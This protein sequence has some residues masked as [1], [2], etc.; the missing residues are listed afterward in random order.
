MLN[1]N[2]KKAFTLAETLI[3]LGIIGIV[4]AM[5]IPTLMTK[6]R[7]HIVET[8]L[9]RT[10]SIITQAIK[11]AEENYGEGFGI[12]IL[13]ADSNI[14]INADRNGYSWELSHAAFETFFKQGIKTV[15]SYTKEYSDNFSIYY[16]TT[17]NKTKYFAWY[18]LL[19]G[20]LL[21]FCMRGNTDALIFLVVPDPHKKKIIAGT[22]TFFIE[23]KPINGNYEYYPLWYEIKNEVTKEKLIEYCAA[24]TVY[25]AYSTNKASFCFELLKING[26]KIP[27]DYPLKF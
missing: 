17:L 15:H 6:Y 18:N 26:W 27:A 1:K 21:G 23:F 9:S 14:N 22:N 3:T 10:Y 12:D 7:M 2:L 19:D 25:P 8:R 5:T 24:N 16:G 4:A 11:I 13:K 20:T